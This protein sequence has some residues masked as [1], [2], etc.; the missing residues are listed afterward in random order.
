L[1]VPE[2]SLCNE[3]CRGICPRCGTDLNTGSCSCEPE[4]DPRWAGLDKLKATLPDE[5]VI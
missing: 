2:Y 4:S 5:E 3:G 1:A